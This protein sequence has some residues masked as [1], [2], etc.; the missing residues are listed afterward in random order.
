MKTGKKVFLIVVAALVALVGLTLVGTGADESILR[1]THSW[2]AQYD[3]AV[4]MSWP[5]NDAMTVLYD[6]LVYPDQKGEPLPHA[7]ARWTVS[8]DGKEWTF[9]LRTDVKFHDG[10]TLTAEDVVFSMDR[11]L[12]IGEGW[13]HLFLPI[14]DRLEAIDDYTVRFHLTM[15]FGPLLAALYKFYIAN[16]DLMMA[17]LVKPGAYG[18][19]GDYGRE[20][21]LDHDAG[22]GPYVMKEFR[23]GEYLLMEIRP[24]KYWGYVTPGAPHQVIQMGVME[25]VTSRL[26]MSNRELEICDPWQAVET[27]EALDRIEGVEIASTKVGAVY[28]VLMHTKKPPLDDIHFRK[29][30]AYATDYETIVQEA[31]PTGKQLHGPVSSVVPGHDPTVFQYYYDLDKALEELKQSKYYEELDQHPVEFHW[32]SSAAFQEK[33]ALTLQSDLAKIGIT[34]KA[35]R[36]TFAQLQDYS[37]DMD[38]SPH[39]YSLSMANPFPEAGSPLQFRYHSDGARGTDQNEWLLDPEY[40]RLLE[41]A[42]ATTDKNERF[43]KYGQLQHYIVDLCPTLFISEFP[44]MQAY[45]TEYMDWPSVY[46]EGIPLIGYHMDPRWIRVFPEKK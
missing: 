16:R 2:P 11:W 4:G 42:F 17:N 7:A 5:S 45:Q 3:P 44:L 21:L 29:A 14:I 19:F 12:T 20:F 36:V 40:D 27:L 43:A 35:V 13:A 28:H 18:E 41:E 33:V 25:A 30:I 31:F 15:K 39:M 9:F 37:S 34:L 22:S 38:A 8:E 1:Y 24:D 23:P 6:T 26:M 10:S 32:I 46:G